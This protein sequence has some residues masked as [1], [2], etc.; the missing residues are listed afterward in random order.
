MRYQEKIE[1]G[2]EKIVGVNCYQLEEDRGR[3][4]PTERPDLERMKAHV[5]RFKAFKRSRSR[6]QVVK[7]ARRAWH[8]PLTDEKD[9]IFARVVEAAEAGVTHGEIVGLPAKRTGLWTSPHRR[10]KSLR[11]LAALV[12][13]LRRG[14]AAALARCLSLIEQGGAIA[15]AIARALRIRRRAAQPSSASAARRARE[16]RR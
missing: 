14:E 9:N 10:L 1:R 11:V 15:D 3:G 7:R 12:E 6:A 13:R 4:K 2:E 5:A 16:N 8:A